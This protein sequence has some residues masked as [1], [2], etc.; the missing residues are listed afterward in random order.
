MTSPIINTS[1]GWDNFYQAV[2][3]EGIGK[4]SCGQRHE[5]KMPHTP[6]FKEIVRFVII[7]FQK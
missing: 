5:D 6:I 1:H 3:K 4:W 7:G 2:Q